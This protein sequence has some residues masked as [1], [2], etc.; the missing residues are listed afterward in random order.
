METNQ[1]QRWLY[2]G[3]LM[4]PTLHIKPGERLVMN[5]VNRLDEPTNIHFHGFHVSPTG[6]SDN[7]FR[8]VETGAN[9]KVCARYPNQSSNR[10]FL[11]SSAPAWSCYYSS[12]WWDVGS[13][14]GR[15]LED[16]LPN[17]LH[18]I[19]QQTFALE[20]FSMEH[21]RKFQLIQY[22]NGQIILPSMVKLILPVNISQGETQL[23]RLANI[24]PATFYNITLPGH[25]FR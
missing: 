19:T 18:N 12:R 4:A 25:T 1:S 20:G 22:T 16:L 9:C 23:W 5:Y 2:N 24:D 6:S 7:I 3:S 8:V 11:V 15:G 10:N 13:N 21:E 14:Q 17:A